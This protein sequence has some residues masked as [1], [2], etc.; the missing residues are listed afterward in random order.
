MKNLLQRKDVPMNL[1]WDLT[2]IYKTHTD[3]ENAIAEVESKLPDFQIKVNNLLENADAFF[4]ALNTSELLVREI[5]KIHVYAMSYFNVETSN[6]DYS[7][8]LSMARSLYVKYATISSLIVPNILNVEKTTIQNFINENSDLAI[9]QTFIDRIFEEKQ[10]VLSK[11]E[12]TLIS[13]LSEVLNSGQ[14]TASILMNADLRYPTMQNE[15]G[16]TIQLTNG[17]Y[18]RFL[19]SKNRSIRKEAFEKLYSSYN[20]IKNTLASTLES[21]VKLNVLNAKLRK[22]NSSRHSSLAVNLVPETTYDT[23][24]EVVNNHL[25]LLHRYVDLR[26]HLL[27]EEKLAAYDLYVPIVDE[28]DIKFTI[29]E[30]KAITLKALAP[31][32]EEYL[33]IIKKAF[34]E[35]WIDWPENEG[36]RSGAYSGGAYDTNPYVLM[37]WQDSIDNLYTLVHELGHSAHSYYSRKNQPYIYANYPIFLAEIASTTNENLLT[38]YFLKTETDPKVRAYI[39]NHYLDGVKST[40]FRQTQFAEFEYRMHQMVENG[41][42][43]NHE[44]LSTLYSEINSKFYGPHVDSTNEIRFEWA[45]IPHFYNSFYVFQYATGFSAASSLAHHIL[46]GNKEDLAK[47]ITFLKSGDSDTPIAIMK[48]AGVNMESKEYIEDMFKIFEE[49]LNELES[50]LKK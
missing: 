23:L 16:E 39:L 12:E 31:L 36:K 30:A 8:W 2:P 27:N 47:Y 4:D 18:A 33:T 10:H 35:R 43:L 34:D 26:A 40:V 7:S 6:T 21:S 1:T 45:R 19:E 24:L 49:R 5:L 46:H 17:L 14:K 50:I 42:P 44:N 28:I 20:S 41:T 9:Y 25:P 38:E 22:Y 29:E 3:W 15:D 32:G 13:S 11:E 48:K 37:N